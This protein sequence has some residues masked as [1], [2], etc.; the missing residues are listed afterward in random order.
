VPKEIAQAW[1][2]ARAGQGPPGQHAPDQHAPDQ[3]AQGQVALSQHPPDQDAPD[4]DTQGQVALSQHAPDQDAY[5]S[6]VFEDLWR[7]YEDPDMR[8]RWDSPLFRI[9]PDEGADSMAAVLQVGS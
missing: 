7:R 4:Q 8:N 1:N 6:A 9:A 5:S 2:A 3:D